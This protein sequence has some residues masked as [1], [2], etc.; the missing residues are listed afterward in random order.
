MGHALEIGEREIWR[1]AGAQPAT[2]FPR[3]R[4]DVPG[5]AS[6]G[7]RDRLFYQPRERGEIKLLA[8]VTPADEVVTI[9][10]GEW[11]AD[12]VAAHAFGLELP[13][14]GRGQIPERNPEVVATGVSGRLHG[15]AAFVDHCHH[16]GLLVPCDCGGWGGAQQ[17]GVATGGGFGTHRRGMQFEARGITLT[18]A[19]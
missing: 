4:T 11:N 8:S 16:H 9:R 15:I 3:G 12:G 17:F 19:S 14:G 2:P 13:V 10:V 18:T 5:V 7:A 6:D 1:L